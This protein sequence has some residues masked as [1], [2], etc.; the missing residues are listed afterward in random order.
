MDTPGA[1]TLTR[2]GS[3]SETPKKSNLT[4][5]TQSERSGRDPDG[6]TE[7]QFTFAMGDFEAVFPLDRIYVSNHMWARS[8][9]EKQFQFGLTAYAVRL[10][11]DVYFLD[12]LPEP[13]NSIARRQ[14]I[15]AIESKKA[16][17]DLYAP[18]EGVWGRISEE[19]LE[20][21]SVINADPYGEGWLFE[22][23]TDATDWQMSPDAY[24]EHLDAAWVVA[25]RTIKGQFH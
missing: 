23:L 1:T 4:D 11:Q 10:L 21:P 25:Q 7:N 22:M 18:T 8:V 6:T 20:D 15:G 5:P 14:E 19:A 3:K 12:W 9:G 2:P 17:S 13:G 16:E 24:R